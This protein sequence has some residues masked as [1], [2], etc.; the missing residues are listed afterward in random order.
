MLFKCV[1][2]CAFLSVFFCAVSSMCVC[3]C[4]IQCALCVVVFS[5]SALYNEDRVNTELFINL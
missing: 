2:E 4:V 5:G 1:C 3:V